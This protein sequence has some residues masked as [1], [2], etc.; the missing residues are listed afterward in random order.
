M[1][2]AEKVPQV[3]VRKVKKTSNPLVFEAYGDARILEKW[4]FGVT[5]T[6]KGGIQ[7]L[8]TWRKV[9]PEWQPDPIWDGQER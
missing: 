1:G 2:N 6:L 8:Q 3:V 9:V 7:M 5:L 4:V